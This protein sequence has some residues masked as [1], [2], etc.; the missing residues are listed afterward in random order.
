MKTKNYYKDTCKVYN[1]AYNVI[2]F[3]EYKAKMIADVPA[4][5]NLIIW[6]SLVQAQAGPH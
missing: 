6:R 2:D 4:T 1:R 3:D 5:K